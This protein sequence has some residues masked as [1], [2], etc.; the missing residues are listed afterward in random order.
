[1][2]LEGRVRL[3]SEGDPF[4]EGRSKKLS[5]PTPATWSRPLTASPSQVLQ[6]GLSKPCF[7]ART[8]RSREGEQCA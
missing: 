2:G 7:Q 3:C 5:S 6:G 4:L 8:L 1:M